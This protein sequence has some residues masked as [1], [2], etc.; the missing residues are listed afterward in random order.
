M[1]ASAWIITKTA[2]I[3]SSPR[4]KANRANSVDVEALSI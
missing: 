3:D 1:Y 2:E 4:S